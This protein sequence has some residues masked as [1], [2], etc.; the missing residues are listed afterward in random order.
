L[1]GN[2]NALDWLFDLPDH[3]RRLLDAG[4][5]LQ[6]LEAVVRK[7]GRNGFNALG[8][9]RAFIKKKFKARPMLE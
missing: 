3:L 6:F 5:S 1:V 2:I 8:A 4:D 9:P 7:L